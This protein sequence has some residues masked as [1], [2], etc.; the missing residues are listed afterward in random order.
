M[1]QV[2]IKEKKYEGKYVALEDLDHP[3]P[4]ADGT[5]PEVVYESAI[6]KGFTDPL[7]IYIP[8]GGMVQIY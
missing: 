2:L 6:K 1:E 7:I 4:I 8:Q 3:S 5:S